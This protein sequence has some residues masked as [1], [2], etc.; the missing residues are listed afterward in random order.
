MSDIFVDKMI[1][2]NKYNIITKQSECGV[3]ASVGANSFVSFNLSPFITTNFII[4][5][6]LKR[7]YVHEATQ[8]PR[9]TVTVEIF[10]GIYLAYFTC[11]T[12]FLE[13][14]FI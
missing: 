14:L 5:A 11:D 4:N 12:K 10:T 2:R 7:G 1:K 3:E 13:N 8:L 6:L 9:I